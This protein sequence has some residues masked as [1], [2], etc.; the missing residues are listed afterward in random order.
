VSTGD[1]AMMIGRFS[2]RSRES[3]SIYPD[4]SYR[5]R[6]R[7]EHRESWRLKL[8]KNQVRTSRGHVVMSS[9]KKEEKKRMIEKSNRQN[10]FETRPPWQPYTFLLSEYLPLLIDSHG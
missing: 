4:H 6:V 8:M 2:K 9:H 3:R 10:H 1:D 5:Y 7:T